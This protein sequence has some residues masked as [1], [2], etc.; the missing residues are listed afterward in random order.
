MKTNLVFKES[1]DKQPLKESSGWIAMFDGKKCEIGKDEARDLWGAKQLAIKKLGVPKSKVGELAIDVAF[2]DDEEG[3]SNAQFESLK[4]EDREPIDMEALEAYANMSEGDNITVTSDM[5]DVFEQALEMAKKY[6]IKEESLK[7]QK[8]I[9]MNEEKQELKEEE[10]NPEVVKKAEAEWATDMQR[11]KDYWM[12]EVY[13]QIENTEDLSKDERILKASEEDI[14]A[15]AERISELIL[16]DDHVWGEINDAIEYYIYHDEFMLDEDLKESAY[17]K[18]SLKDALKELGFES[19]DGCWYTYKGNGVFGEIVNR[20]QN[21]FGKFKYV[22]EPKSLIQINCE[23]SLKEEKEEPKLE[24]FDEQMDFLA[25]DEQE[26]IDGYERVLALVEDE[27]VKEQLEKILVEEKAHKEFLEKV[28]E[29]KSLEYSHEEHEEEVEKE[30]EVEVIDE[31]LQEE[32]KDESLKEGEELVYVVTEL[33]NDMGTFNSESEAIK[34]AKEHNHQQVEKRFKDDLEGDYD[35]VWS[36]EKFESLKEEKEEELPKEVTIDIHSLVDDDIDLSGDDYNLD[37]PISDWLSDNY[38][39]C[40]FGF[41]YEYDFDKDPDFVYV[42]DIEWDTSE[43]LGEDLVDLD[44]V[45]DDFGCF[46]KEEKEAPTKVESISWDDLEDD[47]LLEDIDE[48]EC[49]IDC[50]EDDCE[51]KHV[52]PKCGKEIC[53]C[54]KIEEGK[55]GFTKGKKPWE[56]KK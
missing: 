15:M 17:D 19:D 40:H 48:E 32:I 24:T 33:G 50:D 11:A 1:L 23:E 7:E 34:F 46:V 13:F 47:A 8:D 43:S 18:D 27:H 2:E 37:E 25:K 38:G 26:A 14:K 16:N 3:T 28:K 31:V 41:N 51:E 10:L 12:N 5:L 9:T 4:E 20:L 53:E 29:D 55:T 39:Y 52:C 6:G 22:D 36:N 45:D 21:K 42:T 54:N 44:D 56:V 30:E 49:D 35:V